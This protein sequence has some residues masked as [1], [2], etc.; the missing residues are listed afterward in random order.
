[1]ESSAVPLEISVREAKELVDRAP[2][3]T[4]I[5]DVREPF[6]REICAIADSKFIPMR[7]IPENVAALPRDKH[8]LILCHHGGRSMRV[9]QFLRAQGFSNVT[10][11]AGGIEAWA[12]EVEPGMPRY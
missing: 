2:A 11:I 7:Q 3:K 6:E 5:I 8:L 9:T 4:E 1:M 10:N 12:E